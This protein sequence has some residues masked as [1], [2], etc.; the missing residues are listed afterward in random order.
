MFV[1]ISAVRQ[2]AGLR[3]L[4]EGRRSATRRGEAAVSKATYG[5]MGGSAGLSFA[6]AGASGA[7]WLRLF[8]LRHTASRTPGVR[9]E[10]ILQ[11][12]WDRADLGRASLISSHR[13]MRAENRGAYADP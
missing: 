8:R 1:H 4:N 6:G 2:Y 11:L 7:S 9:H 3:G 13:R 10:A 12:T 5:W